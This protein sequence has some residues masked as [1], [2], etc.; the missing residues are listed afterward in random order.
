MRTNLLK[1]LSVFCLNVTIKLLDA[2]QI[3]VHNV[4]IG[5]PNTQK[6]KV[7]I[8]GGVRGLGSAHCD[9]ARGERGSLGF[10]LLVSVFCDFGLRRDW[11]WTEERRG[12]GG[13]ATP[14]FSVSLKPDAPSPPRALRTF[15]VEHPRRCAV[16]APCHAS[17]PRL[18]PASLPLTAVRAG[19]TRTGLMKTTRK[20]RAMLSVGLN[21]LALMFSTTAFTTTYWCEGTQ[22]VPKPTCSKQRRH[23]CID[24]G[25]NETDQSK[26]HYSWETGDDRFLFRRFHT[27]I[28]YSCEENIHEAGAWPQPHGRTTQ[29]QS[30]N[31]LLHST[32][33]L[34]CNQK[35]D[36]GHLRTS[37][38]SII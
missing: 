13:Y 19:W 7:V 21:L 23:N 32:W 24:Y 16:R 20:C 1:N 12:A 3:Y 25:V 31:L 37:C 9:D 38:V 5:W 10:S 33:W 11:G 26:V 17:P 18:P 30:S 2:T 14:L 35:T 29:Q 27:G 6:Y 15:T 34:I 4:F 36:C 28:W 22:R 8:V